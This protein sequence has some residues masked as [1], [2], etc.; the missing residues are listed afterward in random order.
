MRNKFAAV[1]SEL[2]SYS[3]SEKLFIF[4]SMLCGFFISAE[5][6]VTKPSS[7]SIFLSAYT[8]KLYPYVWLVMVPVNLLVVTIYNRYLPKIGCFKM[9][10]TT[11][12]ITIG[13]NEIGLHYLG[14]VKSVPFILALWK[15]IYVLLMFQ[16]LWSVIHA[17][18]DKKRAKYLYGLIFGVGGIGAILGSLI[19]AMLAVKIGSAS[20]LHITTPLFLLF[21]VCFY[22]A[23]RAAGFG[24]GSVG[25]AQMKKFNGSLSEGFQ[26]IRSSQILKY[27]LLIV[28]F[29]QVTSTLIEY[30]FSAHLEK[31]IPNVD[32]RTEYFGSIRGIINTVNLILQFVGSF[33]LIQCFGLKR[34]HV[35]IP[36]VLLMNAIG[37]L[38][39]PTFRMLT[40]SY[41][42]I[43]GCDYS[44]FTIIKEMLYVPLKLEEK[45]KAKAVIDVFAYRTAKVFATGFILAMQAF[46]PL[47]IQSSALSWG[48]ILII[49]LWLFATYFMLKKN[50]EIEAEQQP[51]M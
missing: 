42:A 25:D 30:Q 12:L 1:K 40:Y 8:V 43:K 49:S 23:I 31:S 32:L 35:I 44:V 41:T 27:I 16:Q 13:I 6:A 3:K 45:F 33:I 10:I 28:I 51:S 19:P 46:V 15:D 37:C 18:I 14:S 21:L 7:T 39:Y 5:S 24:A 36:G 50:L 47:R 38:V 34:S 29:M 4:F 2:L 48:P 20:L 11:V 26:L 9:A 17:K 22:L